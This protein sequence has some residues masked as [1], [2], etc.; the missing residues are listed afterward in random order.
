MRNHFEKCERPTPEVGEPVWRFCTG[1]Q[2]LTISLALIVQRNTDLADDRY[3]GWPPVTF[4]WLQ[5]YRLQVQIWSIWP[6]EG[7]SCPK[8]YLIV[9]LVFFFFFFWRHVWR[10]FV[11]SFVQRVRYPSQVWDDPLPANMWEA[12]SWSVILTRVP[13]IWLIL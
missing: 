9:T 4:I 2:F 6:E 5:C 8:I 12:N 1:W 11:H 13:R 10:M 7:H 3:H